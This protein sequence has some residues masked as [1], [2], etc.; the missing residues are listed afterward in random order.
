MFRFIMMM[1][2]NDEYFRSISLLKYSSLYRFLDFSYK[3]LVGMKVANR[4]LMTN[5]ERWYHYD[6]LYKEYYNLSYARPV[7]A[8]AVTPQSRRSPPRDGFDLRRGGPKWDRFNLGHRHDALITFARAIV[9]RSAPGSI[10]R[11]NT[12]YSRRAHFR[13]ISG[14][15]IGR[16]L[17][18]LTGLTSARAQVASNVIVVVIISLLAKPQLFNHRPAMWI[19]SCWVLVTFMWVCVYIRVCVFSLFHTLSS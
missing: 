11:P 2:F 8:N 6:S 19:Q 5:W 12:T 15:I 4:S 16:G 13:A 1:I 17:R 7:T 18:G 3:G 10:N 14:G 9:K